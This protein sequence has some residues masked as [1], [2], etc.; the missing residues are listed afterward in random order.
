MERTL[1][2]ID[3]DQYIG[4]EGID[5]IANAI[6]DQ[7]D[8]MFAL[9]LS[10]MLANAA[11]RVEQEVK[12]KVLEQIEQLGEKSVEVGGALFT[13]ANG[14]TSWDFSDD[15]KHNDITN[16]IEVLQRE[17]KELE[18]D[19]KKRGVGIPV[20]SPATVRVKFR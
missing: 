13:Y 15:A 4:Q 5:T 3:G 14:R 9:G 1:V 18:G 12:A 6:I 20:V 7:V 17:L 8:P 11:K 10:K 2:K 19:L 16:Q